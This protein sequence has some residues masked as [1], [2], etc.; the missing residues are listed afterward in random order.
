[1]AAGDGGENDGGSWCTRRLAVATPERD[2]RSLAFGP[3]R[4]GERYDLTT[5]AS[6]R[7]ARRAPSSGWRPPESVAPTFLSWAAGF[8]DMEG[9]QSGDL[10]PIFVSPGSWDDMGAILDRLGVDYR[11]LEHVPL[12]DQREGVV[13]LNCGSSWYVETDAETLD[14]FVRGGGSLLA[15]DLAEDA[16]AELTGATFVDG[17]WGDAVEATVVDPELSDLLGRERLVLDFDTA[18]KVVDDL[19]ASGNPLLRSA[20]GRVIAYQDSH[21]AGEVVY[22]SFHNHSQSSE[23]EDALLGILLMVPIAESAGT[24]VTET[25]TTV[26]GEEPSGED[27]GSGSSASGTSVYGDSGSGIED[28][29]AGG[30]EPDFYD[31]SATTAAGRDSEPESGTGAG[32]ASGSIDDGAI[33]VHLRAASGGDGALQRTLRPGESV[34]LGRADLRGVADDG[35]L[36]YVSGTH[37]ELRNPE[38]PPADCLE[39]RDCDSTNGTS[40]DGRSIADGDYHVLEPGT[41]LTLAD[42]RVTFGVGME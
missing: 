18:I 31:R 8:G 24:T 37:L 16:I 19:P 41:G 12:A 17:D 22:T 1:M 38:G 26:V 7:P 33:T 30:D 14:A 27:D 6:D 11:M 21:G 34:R 35:V 42:D 4:D 20:D 25:Y 40:L 28:T 23:V 10:P 9:F 5:T 39:V 32:T 36:S 15:S 13:L 3:D 29:T 2:R